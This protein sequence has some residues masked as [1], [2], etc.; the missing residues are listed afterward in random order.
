MLGYLR[1]AMD[2]PTRELVYG[3]IAKDIDQDNPMDVRKLLDQ[4]GAR[5]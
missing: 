1:E 2:R 4:I 3:E 5:T